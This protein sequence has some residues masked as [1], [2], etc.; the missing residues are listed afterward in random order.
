MA[1]ELLTI[2]NYMAKER[3]I[4]KDALIKALETAMESAVAKDYGSQD[5]FRLRIDPVTCEIKGFKILEVVDDDPM[6]DKE[7]NIKDALEIDPEIVCG[8]LLEVESTPENLGRVAAQTAKQVIL[9]KIRQAENDQIFEEY[10]EQ[11]GEIVT[12]SVKRFQRNDILVELD[13]VEGIIPAKERIETEDFR[14]GERIS[15]YVLSVEKGMNGSAPKITLS[16]TTPAFVRRLFEMEST[17]INEGI[18]K[19]VNIAREPGL[20]TKMAVVTEDPRIDPVGAC[21]GIR[22]VRV[23][24]V[25]DE[26]GG[27]KI[28]IVPYSEVI[29]TY[30]T[31]ALAPA[32]GIEVEIDKE[33]PKLAHVT[34]TPDQ[35]SLAIGKQGLN[36]KLSAKLLRMKINITKKS[37]KEHDAFEKQLMEAINNLAVVDGISH[38]DAEILVKAGF[39]TVEGISAVDIGDI[40]ELAGITQEHAESIYSAALVAM[41]S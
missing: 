20:R 13:K 38:S 17:E 31:N 37:D 6:S 18:V 29:E 36:V 3:G 19:I 7:I 41:T 40:V 23:R 26:L 15:A 4:A 21:V 32:K 2:V 16:R 24:N 35:Y 34:V 39:V 30:V 25:V 28:D 9:Q 1:N 12:G 14:I 10:K 5:D 27:E 22:G 33:N 8:E 11:Q